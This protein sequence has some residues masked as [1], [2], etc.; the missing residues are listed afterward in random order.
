MSA[1]ELKVC[2]GV[3]ECLQ[4]GHMR[5]D[6]LKKY[7]NQG[8]QG[9]AA[10]VQAALGNV[11]L[12]ASGSMVTMAD[13]EVD[14]AVFAFWIDGKLMQGQFLSDAFSDDA[15]VRFGDEDVVKVIYFTE[16]DEN[17]IVAVLKPSENTLWLP[18]MIGWGTGSVAKQGIK[19]GILIGLGGFLFI[20]IAFY[21]MDSNIFSDTKYLKLMLLSQSGL[22]FVMGVWEFFGSKSTGDFSTKIFRLLGL[23]NPYWLDLR[24]YSRIVLYGDRTGECTYDLN[25]MHLA[26][27][28][29]A[30][31]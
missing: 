23:P 24:P 29:K 17:H 14:M 20:S 13:V 30:K 3:I 5:V 11:G 6:V 31:M 25:A 12:A 1:S 15:K 10:A 19:H 18:L 22:G 27:K 21:F 7:V 2:E 16:G 28:A 4:V 26:L 8:A 9:A